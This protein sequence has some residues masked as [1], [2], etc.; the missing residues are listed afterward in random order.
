MGDYRR[1][2]AIGLKFKIMTYRAQGTATRLKAIN[3]RLT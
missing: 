1:C 2:Y 3:P